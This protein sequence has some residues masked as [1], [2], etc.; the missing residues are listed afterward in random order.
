MNILVVDDEP[1]I[2]IS[3]EKLIRTCSQEDCV[4]HAHNGHQMLDALA[5]RDFALAFVDI[6]MPGPSGLEAIKRARDISPFTRYYIMT[7]FDEFEYAKQAIKLKVDDYLMKPLDLK[8]IRET[9]TAARL[10]VH[11]DQ[12]HKKSVFRNWLESTLNG[13]DSYFNEYMGYYCGL[14][15]VAIDSSGASAEEI[16]RPFLPY[17]DHL[18]SVFMEG[19]LVLLCFAKKSD[20]ILEMYRQLSGLEYP[21]GVTCFAA[22]ITKDPRELKNHLDALLDRSCLKVLLGTGRFYHLAPLMD[23][24]QLECGFCRSCLKWQTAFAAQDYTAFS[25]QSE[26]MV[27][28]LYRHP[29]LQKYQANVLSFLALTLNCPGEIPDDPE[30]LKARLSLAA[31]NFLNGPDHDTKVQSIIRF[32]QEHYQENISAAELSERFGLSP[33]YISNLLKNALGI[34]YNDYVTQLRLNRAK[35]LLMS[36]RMS[37]KEIT[38]ACGYYSQSHFTRLFLEHE[39]CTPSE[40]RKTDAGKR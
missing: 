32:I 12:E 31:R 17:D 15:A 40:Y 11:L 33:N 39:G 3:I 2:H 27:S 26:L 38:A 22:S 18:V 8:T 1:L 6:K 13:R 28:Q 37:V 24:G 35:E 30:A 4:F 36:T 5:E 19:G 14:M 29:E 9:I 21:A 25:S 16:R 23:R 20:Y 34:R 7:G 10:H